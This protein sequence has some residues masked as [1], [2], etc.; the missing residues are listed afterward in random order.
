MT[1]SP[2][3]WPLSPAPSRLSL[4]RPASPVQGRVCRRLY[5]G[6]SAGGC[7]L[8]EVMEEQVQVPESPY[9]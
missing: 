8:E 3:A 1:T 4:R 2:R 6:G 7:T 5:R 9:L